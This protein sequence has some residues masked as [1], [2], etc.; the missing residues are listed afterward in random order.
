MDTRTRSAHVFSCNKQS[1]NVSASEVVKDTPP[2]TSGSP[3]SYEGDGEM[4]G[5][6]PAHASSCGTKGECRALRE[7]RGTPHPNSGAVRG[8]RSNF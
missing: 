2:L 7:P 3:H 8:L 5:V 4:D 1:G 6:R